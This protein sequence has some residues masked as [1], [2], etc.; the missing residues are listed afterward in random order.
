ML[1]IDVLEY[2]LFEITINII[3][4]LVII[5]HF[6]KSVMLTEEIEIGLSTINV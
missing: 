2:L 5:S 1:S 6:N 3:E 4:M